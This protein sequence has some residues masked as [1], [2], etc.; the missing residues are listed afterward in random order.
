MNT[1]FFIE[2]NLY[3]VTALQSARETSENNSGFADLKLIKQDTAAPD[4]GTLEHNFFVLDGTREEFPDMPDNL[5]YFS[6]EQAGEDGRFA[7]DPSVDIR[8]AESH[9]SVGLTLRFLEVYPTELEIFWYD[10]DGA[11]KAKRTFYPD[12]LIYFCNHQV[13]EYWGIKIVFKKALPRHNVKLQYI[14][15]GTS[16]TWDSGTLKSGKLINDVDPISDR[17]STDKL[18]FDFVDKYDDFNIGNQSGLHKTFQRK[19]NMEAYEMVNGEKIILGTFFLDSSQTTANICKMN[20][21]DYKGMLSNIDFTE[22]R[23]YNGEPAGV[24]IA[25]I[26]EAAGILDYDVDVETA[27]T[28]LYGTLKIQSCQKALREVLFACGSIINTSR[29]TGVS[30]C[31]SDKSSTVTIERGRK[32]STTFEIDRYVSDINV[33]YATWALD[34]K[35]SEITKGEYGAGTHMI[36]LSSPAANMTTN[37][38]RIIRQMPYY[39]ILEIGQDV[40]SDVVISG[41]KYVKEELSVLRRVEHIKSGEIRNTKSFAGTLLNFASAQRVADSILAYYQLQQIIKTKHISAEEK[42]GD[43]VEIENSVK[44]H[45]NFVAAI[46]SATTDLTGGFI[47]TATYRGYYKLLTDYYLPGEIYTGED[48][49]IL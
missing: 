12:S 15:Y 8:F 4:Y 39:V 21:I 41:R 28:P 45:G 24:V 19:Q 13:E 33:K 3:D 32:F 27:G 6:R 46:E 38:G 23:M 47:S 30:I 22:G 35:I 17:I 5:V 43:W 9:T 7:E 11:L 36:Q 18:S 48:V 40:R 49:G 26:M 37:A 1:E 29:R 44:K 34:E 2:Y 14:K 31:K 16:V 10:I 20:A 25:E 42:A